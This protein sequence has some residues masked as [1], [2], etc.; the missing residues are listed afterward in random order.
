M[1]NVKVIGYISCSSPAGQ[2]SG[3]FKLAHIKCPGKTRQSQ[4]IPNDCPGKHPYRPVSKLTTYQD[5]YPPNFF[6]S[7]PLKLPGIIWFLMEGNADK[8]RFKWGGYATLLTDTPCWHDFE[9]LF[10]VPHEDQRRKA[11]IFSANQVL[12]LSWVKGAAI[13]GITGNANCIT[14]PLSYY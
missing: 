7:F 6:P 10:T 8:L 4:V 11:S 1:P 12:K 2:L 9:C 3:Q 14:W 5:L 13:V